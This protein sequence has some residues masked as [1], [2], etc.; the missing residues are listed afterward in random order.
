M[1]WQSCL[2]N[3]L[4]LPM[5]VRLLSLHLTI[6][7][8]RTWNRSSNHLEVL[9][10]V[11]KRSSTCIEQITLVD[12]IDLLSLLTKDS[13]LTRDSLGCNP[14]FIVHIGRHWDCSS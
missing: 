14:L 1:D 2:S 9:M 4:F 7:A 10:T 13:L 8:L 3:E 12:S 5:C 11:H 6:T